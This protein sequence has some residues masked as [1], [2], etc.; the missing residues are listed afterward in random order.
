M[1]GRRS[2]EPERCAVCGL[3]EGVMR[4]ADG[5]VCRYCVPLG[6]S[7]DMPTA[8]DVRACH[9]ADPVMIGRVEEFEETWSA[10]DLRFDDV[11]GLILRGPYPN[12]CL[13]VLS[14]REVA[15][16]SVVI[17]GSPTAYNSV[18]GR[19]AVFS[20]AT[21]AY[22]REASKKAD[23]IVLNIETSRPDFRVR[24]FPV[25]TRRSSVSDTRDGC[26]RATVELSRRLDRIVED[27]IFGGND[28]AT[29]RGTCPNPR[30]ISTCPCRARPRPPQTFTGD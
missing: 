28:R 3:R 13:P 21:D 17:D 15:G 1:F 26:M 4:I 16:Y 20:A 30:S 10:G 12:R 18:G 25:R 2:K 14:Y 27:N 29:D 7:F 23:E 8:E 24:P 22:I 11:H 5:Y 9:I 6:H 19:R